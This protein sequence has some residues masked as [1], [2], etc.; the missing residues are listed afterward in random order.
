MAAKIGGSAKASVS[1]GSGLSSTRRLPG[2]SPPAKPA[3]PPISVSPAPQKGPAFASWDSQ[4][5][6]HRATLKA[7]QPLMDKWKSEPA[8]SSRSRAGTSLPDAVG[9]LE[10]QGRFFSHELPSKYIAHAIGQGA[11]QSGFQTSSAL[12]LPEPKRDKGRAAAAFVFTRQI[13]SH[14]EV[15]TKLNE[16][17]VG[18]TTDAMLVFKPSMFADP[19]QPSFFKTIDGAHHSP[20]IMP[21]RSRKGAHVAEMSDHIARSSD[22]TL[23]ANQ[24]QG[25]HGTVE[26]RHLAAIVLKTKPGQE[27]ATKK[28]FIEQLHQTPRSEVL[29]PIEDRRK[30]KAAITSGAAKKPPSEATMAKRHGAFETRV[31]GQSLHDRLEQSINVDT[32]PGARRRR[33]E[34]LVVPLSA[35]TERRDVPAHLPK[36]A[37]S[38]PIHERNP[39]LGSS[40]GKP[41]PAFFKPRG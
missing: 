27:A 23:Q 12:G 15:R 32:E 31:V 38:V 39:R 40:L 22:A 37:R 19:G 9:Q 5:D 10:A 1:A 8:S 13:P 4:K 30:I 34:D 33:V 17:Q 35:A 2:G 26:L 29:P 3:L 7:V 24:E 20:S 36:P 21:H 28:A 25:I 11:V 6:H 41:N 14:P 18:A 16:G